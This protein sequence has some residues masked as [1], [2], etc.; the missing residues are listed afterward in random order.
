MK[1]LIFKTFRD[2][3]AYWGIK[4]SSHAYSQPVG[5]TKCNMS[6]YE[7]DREMRNN[8]HSMGWGK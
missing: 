1:K 8:R 2:L 6:K 4:P 3:A 7:I 5:L